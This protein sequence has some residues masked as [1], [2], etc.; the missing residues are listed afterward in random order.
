MVYCIC[1]YYL[2]QREL[3]KKKLLKIISDDVTTKPG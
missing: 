3:E 2:V 1:V